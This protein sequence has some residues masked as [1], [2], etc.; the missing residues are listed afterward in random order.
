MKRWLSRWWPVGCA[1]AGVVSALVDRNWLAATWA[2]VAGLALW[3]LHY[4]ELAARDWRTFYHARSAEAAALRALH[5][6]ERTIRWGGDIRAADDRWRAANRAWAAAIDRLGDRPSPSSLPSPW[7]RVSLRLSPCGGPS[8]TPTCPTTSKGDG[9]DRPHHPGAVARPTGPAHP[10]HTRP[11]AP[12]ADAAPVR[13]RSGRGARPDRRSLPARRQ[14]RGVS[15]DG[16]TGP[17]ALGHW[18]TRPLAPAPLATEPRSHL[19]VR[20]PRPPRRII[21]FYDQDREQDD[22]TPAHGL[23][24]P[25]WLTAALDGHT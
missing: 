23:T 25:D 1:V 9:N 15:L 12:V 5:D 19:T 17:L 18:S 2:V 22:E 14:R 8:Q 6:L 20:A 11:A 13:C 24:R 21:P 10:R 4:T 16:I 3:A 7:W